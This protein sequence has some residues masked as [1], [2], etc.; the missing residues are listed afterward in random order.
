MTI[1]ASDQKNNSNL[2]NISVAKTYPLGFVKSET[3]GTPLLRTEEQ[4][5]AIVVAKNRSATDIRAVLTM[6]NGEAG[7]ATQQGII[8]NRLT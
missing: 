4:T 1:A 3:V 5:S 7:T 2:S 8:T 6:N